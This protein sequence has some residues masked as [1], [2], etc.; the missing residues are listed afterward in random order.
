[1]VV[2]FLVSNF[3]FALMTQLLGFGYKLVGFFYDSKLV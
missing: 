1:M 3:F 2:K